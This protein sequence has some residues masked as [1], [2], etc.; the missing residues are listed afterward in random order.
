ML[1]QPNNPN[2]SWESKYND[3]VKK[4]PRPARSEA[5]FIWDEKYNGFL[6][7]NPKPL[8]PEDQVS[9]E[10]KYNAFLVIHPKPLKSHAQVL[11]DL[12]YNAFLKRN[13][14]P[15]PPAHDH[16]NQPPPPH[17]TTYQNYNNNNASSLLLNNNNNSY[18]NYNNALWNQ[19]YSSSHYYY[20]NN[21]RNPRP[22]PYTPISS[23][24]FTNNNNN[25]I[26]TPLSPITNQQLVTMPSTKN[27]VDALRGPDG[28]LPQ[29]LKS[30]PVYL[31]EKI[32]NEIMDGDPNIQ[33]DDIAG[34]E[35]AKK[36][37]N[38]MVILPMLRPDI[39]TGCRSTGRG[40]LLFGP[41]GTGKTMIGKA[42]AAEAKATFFY[43]SSSSLTSKWVRTNENLVRALFGVA[44]CRQPAVIFLDEIDSL[45]SKRNSN[46]H[47]GIRAQK[48][49]LLIEM[50]GF[51][52]G[53]DQVLVIEATNRP[54]D[55][56]EAAMRRLTKRF[57]VPLPSSE[58]RACIICNLL[59]KDG[60]LELSPEDIDSICKLTEGY[61][62]SDMKIFVKDAAMGPVREALK[63]CTDPAKLIKDQ[64]RPVTMQVC[65][66]KCLIS[67][68]LDIKILSNSS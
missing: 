29:K 32:C 42:I 38:E 45:L 49:Q 20:Y 50:D 35:H 55:L 62:G 31:I 16:H 7:S 67:Q 54:Q 2:A 23:N 65:R 40:L 39:F 34:L 27:G 56:D 58:A 8:R 33:W 3:F 11:W 57:Y 47:Q 18:P 43:I 4:N 59:K 17:L 60:L 51:A 30:I 28:Q 1:P 15:P 21:N 9:W 66:Y 6:I 22:Y 41:P 24:V 46:D 48:T 12:S 26:F 13:Q 5:E 64:L 14:K 53:N 61:S 37:V 44:S 63:E 25:A 36:C 52:S 19:L 10:Q 68:I